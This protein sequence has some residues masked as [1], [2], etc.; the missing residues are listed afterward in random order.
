MKLLKNE[1]GYA[2]LI[3]L[4]LIVFI[5]IISAVFMRNSIS[6]AKQENVVD[7]NQ[8]AVVAAEMGIELINTSYENKFKEVKDK[9]LVD[10]QKEMKT[11]EEK[12]LKDNSITDKEK[13]LLKEEKRL[14]VLMAEDLIGFFPKSLNSKITIAEKT[15]EFI[16]NIITPP[17]VVIDDST[18]RIYVSVN[19]KSK[20]VSKTRNAELT[21][22]LF[23]DIPRLIKV[24]DGNSSQNSTNVK[25]DWFKKQEIPFISE[26]PTKPCNN[27]P[28]KELCVATKTTQLKNVENSTLYFSGNLEK[29]NAGNVGHDFKSSKI[30]VNGNVG[31]DKEYNWNNSENVEIYAKGNVNLKNGNNFN[32]SVVMAEGEIYL[33]NVKMDNMKLYSESNFK[34]DKFNPI[35]S[36]DIFVGKNLEIDKGSEIERSNVMV[37]AN[38]VLQKT[39]SLKSSNVILVNNLEIEGNNEKV[40]ATNNTFLCVGGNINLS[41][42]T[43]DTSSHVYYIA[44]KSKGKIKNNSSNFHP[45]K[46]SE[47][48]KDQNVLFNK[49]KSKQ[50]DD[51]PGWQTPI[52]D[53]KY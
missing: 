11:S 5:T 44:E 34:V 9:I 1:K 41:E 33:D 52:R 22:E 23:F 20:G 42:I 14:R 27:D 26:L 16:T 4:F 10:R 32:N 36:S 17:Y 30:Y 40:N 35:K 37:L 6:N 29:Y 8:L 19:G 18:P 53:V 13:E 45:M 31:N 21:T 28:K 49:C 38:T 2:M 15:N 39:L 51:M 24:N 3:V 50:A 47:F 12:I 7:E 48:Q 46:D 25:W 43:V